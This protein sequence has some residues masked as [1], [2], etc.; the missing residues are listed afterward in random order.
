MTA[1]VE[2]LCEDGKVE[3]L[4]HLSSLVCLWFLV[5]SLFAQPETFVA[6]LL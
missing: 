1:G 4:S 6:I 5:I 2:A 3:E